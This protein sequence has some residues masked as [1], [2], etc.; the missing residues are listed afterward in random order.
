MTL[1]EE[2]G[3]LLLPLSH[4]TR[5]GLERKCLD[6]HPLELFAVLSDASPTVPA[7]RQLA[8]VLLAKKI[9]SCWSGALHDGDKVKLQ[10][11]LISLMLAL[12]AYDW[13]GGVVR[14]LVDCTAC[15]ADCLA[16]KGVVW[17]D[18]FLWIRG[19]A[20]DTGASNMHGRPSLMGS[21][22]RKRRAFLYLLD[23]LL[24][25]PAWQD[26]LEPHVMEVS[27]LLCRIALGAG[28]Q[29]K[30]EELGNMQN[31]LSELACSKHAL[32]S[33]G[34]L[35]VVVRGEDAARIFHHQV[36]Q[37]LLSHSIM[38]SD[39][40]ESA[41]EAL[42]RAAAVD[43]LLIADPSFYH[44][45]L[46][47][48]E[49]CPV[50]QLGLTAAVSQRGERRMLALRVLYSVAESHSR[51]L[52]TSGERAGQLS[53][54][55]VLQTLVGRV[56]PDEVQARFL[57]DS[58]PFPAEAASAA[59]WGAEYALL[60]RI[61][62][63]LPDKLVLPVIYKLAC[64]S[65]SGSDVPSKLAAFASLRAVLAGCMSSV[66]KQLQKIARI[67]LRALTDSQ[68]HAVTFV[69][70]A[71]L[72]GLVPAETRC[73]SC[74]LA[75]RLLPPLLQQLQ[76]L[77]LRDAVFPC[78]LR[79]LEAA[80]PQNGL[81][82]ARM[83]PAFRV[84][85]S[86][87]AIAWTV[88]KLEELLQAGRDSSQIWDAI[89]TRLCSLLAALLH[90]Q[91]AKRNGDKTLKTLGHKLAT[92]L[93]HMLMSASSLE[94]RSMALEA[95]GAWM[96]LCQLCDNGRSD[97]PRA[98]RELQEL[99][100]ISLRAAERGL[101]DMDAVT[102]DAAIRFLVSLG[103]L[104]P[105][106]QA[107]FAAGLEQC[108]RK[109]TPALLQ[110]LA[111]LLASTQCLPIQAAEWSRLT[112]LL[113]SFLEQ[114]DLRGAA[115]DLVRQLPLTKLTV[116]LLVRIATLLDLEDRPKVFCSLCTAAAHM[117]AQEL[118]QPAEVSEALRIL[119]TVVE[120]LKQK[121]STMYSRGS[122]AESSDE[123]LLAQSERTECTECT[124]YFQSEIAYISKISGEFIK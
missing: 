48:E 31:L 19:I 107:A 11:G 77:Q 56:A 96:K 83:L 81:G 73:G 94:S 63:R 106:P 99:L 51:L 97:G 3:Q 71:D 12:D 88:Q 33:L 109:P 69:L 98:S 39:L 105:S 108:A 21:H 75:E 58:A 28:A 43:E 116:V 76:L 36:V 82:Q 17:Q 1:K 59:E 70:I 64:Q 49:L 65:L 90:R 50:V 4:E 60:G 89:A 91:P 123:D 10:A 118:E 87:V 41:L 34:S 14:S 45:G 68:L 22:T 42:S 67:V 9:P 35:A 79:A 38:G 101:Q 55:E 7:V 84:Q 80:C 53:A 16:M 5:Q 114:P 15:V 8:G 110:A 27:E 104:A 44:P 29:A 113:S 74:R 32:E 30:V 62:K 112:T 103:A 61:S 54:E 26:L 111:S 117:A 47:P 93:H 23:R 121:R 115:A 25:S 40:C 6:M 20:S 120:R 52:C 57:I 13:D 24:E 2:L 124:E 78:A 95:S 102:A 72:C 37:L 86:V 100:A 92:I 46:A 122:L 18:L 66:K 85:S 119:R